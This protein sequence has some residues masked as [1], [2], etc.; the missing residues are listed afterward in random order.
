MLD[1][2]L[3]RPL[4]SLGGRIIKLVVILAKLQAKR[5]F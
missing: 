1:K 3:N 4:T 2:L 5:Q